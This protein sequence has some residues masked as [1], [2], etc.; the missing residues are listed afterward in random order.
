VRAYL[1][2]LGSRL[3][4]ILRANFSV[5]LYPFYIT[6]RGALMLA[7]A[8]ENRAMNNSARVQKV[9]HDVANQQ[10]TWQSK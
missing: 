1:S 10:A 5:Q 3:A 8:V 9:A 2:A 4:S 7:M 6:E